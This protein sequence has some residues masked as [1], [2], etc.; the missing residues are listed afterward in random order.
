V[1]YFQFRLNG[2]A[3]HYALASTSLSSR[4]IL[5]IRHGSLMSLEALNFLNRA[6]TARCIV[7]EQEP[8]PSKIH[9]D[10]FLCTAIECSLNDVFQHSLSY[11]LFRGSRILTESEDGCQR[12][13][14]E[15]IRRILSCF[16]SSPS[17]YNQ[18]AATVRPILNQRVQSI[19]DDW[20]GFVVEEPEYMADLLEEGLHQDLAAVRYLVESFLIGP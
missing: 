11:V 1:E 20:H 17:A 6:F 16:G 5:A 12:M 3:D 14:W 2:V 9:A 8:F 7:L 10:N 4:C 13:N 15:D 19:L 18:E